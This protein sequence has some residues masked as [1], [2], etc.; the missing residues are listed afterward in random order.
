MFNRG[1]E[2]AR[3]MNGGIVAIPSNLGF[4][5][6][7]AAVERR[8]EREY[9]EREIPSLVDI[10][11][12]TTTF[13]KE[14]V[15]ESDGQ[16]NANNNKTYVIHRVKQAYDKSDLFCNERLGKTI[17]EACS[18]KRKQIPYNFLILV[19]ASTVEGN[20]NGY[21]VVVSRR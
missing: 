14:P 7:D 12:N 4:N 21:R 18:F 16:Q 9:L 3:T 10:R 17:V 1:K 6:A 13:T 19:L 5:T 20:C 8:R 15:Y 11:E 2:R